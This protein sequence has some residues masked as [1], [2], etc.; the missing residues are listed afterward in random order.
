MKLKKGLSALILMV[1]ST[2]AFAAGSTGAA[3]PTGT[4][5]DTYDQIL[6]V[7]GNYAN[8]DG[9]GLTGVVVVQTSN[10]NY[11][12]MLA[13]ILSAGVSQKQLGFWVS[14]CVYTPWGGTAALVVDVSVNF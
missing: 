11:K 9:C 14:G 10:A 1:L 2:S 12:D 7:N 5:I 8:P 3:A 6:A 4:E 13:A